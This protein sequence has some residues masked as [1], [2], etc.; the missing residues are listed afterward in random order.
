MLEKTS[1]WKTTVVE[2]RRDVLVRHA[3]P[4]HVVEKIV[5]EM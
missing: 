5:S 3:P 4:S 1:H 2:A